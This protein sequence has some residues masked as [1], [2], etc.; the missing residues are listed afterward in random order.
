MNKYQ[1]KRK[2][3]VKLNQLM[4]LMIFGI[5]ATYLI[6]NSSFNF[7]KR[8]L[9]YDSENIVYTESNLDTIII[10]DIEIFEEESAGI[11]V[12]TF[13]EDTF[14]FV[15]TIP[16][17]YEHQK[18]IFSRS[19]ELGL[20]YKMLLAVI[21][22]ESEFNYNTVSATNDYGYFQVNKINHTNLADT[23]NTANQPLDPVVNITWGTYMLA[24]LFNYWSEKGLVDT[25]LNHSVWSSYNKG[26]TGFKKYGF[27]ENYISKI[28][29]NM[30]A[31]EITLDVAIAALNK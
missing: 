14:I 2:Y 10:D 6:D 25:E 29:T 8:A 11:I 22:T 28:E 16:M 23:L 19:L 3:Q 21:A 7:A 27:A 5:M 30:Q 31:I 12:D 1:L 4:F 9:A 15:E 24:D 26:L 17:P 18:F 20:D 13:S